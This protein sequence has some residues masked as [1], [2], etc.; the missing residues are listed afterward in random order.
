MNAK[1]K[2]VSKSGRKPEQKVSSKLNKKP[3]ATPVEAKQDVLKLK[4]SNFFTHYYQQIFIFL[5]ASIALYWTA[6]SNDFYLKWAEEYSLFIPTRY[7]FQDCMKFSGGLLTYTGTFLT[8]FYYYPALGSII[9]IAI[10]FLIQYLTLKTFR[11]SRKYYPLS[12]VPVLMLL[13]SIT[14]LGYVWMLLKSPGYFFSNA[15][16]IAAFL[17]MFIVYRN[18][19]NV[20]LR[21]AVLMLVIIAGYPLFGFYALY[22]GFLCVFYELIQ[23]IRNKQVLRMIPVVAGFVLIVVVPLYFYYY[24]YHY[25]QFIDIYTAGLPRFEYNLRELVL[26]IPFLVILSAFVLFVA[27]LFPKADKDNV[28]HRGGYLLSVSTFVLAVVV[29]CTMSYRDENFTAGTRIYNAIEHNNWNRV[30]SIVENLEGKPTKNIV[31]CYRMASLLTISK[32]AND[33]ELTQENTIPPRCIR[34]TLPIKV[35]MG[36]ISFYYNSGEINKCYRWC[37]ENSVEFGMRVA[38]LKYMVKCA[39]VNG[40]YKLAEKYNSIL[41]SSMFYK[42]WAKRYQNF[43]ENP[44]LTKDD[45]EMVL[46]RSLID[47]NEQEFEQ[48]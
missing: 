42:S 26:W 28:K 3:V 36:G 35:Q 7:Y 6:V 34:A 15:L 47:V 18:T 39:I 43:I 5:F 46:L 30:I 17:L 29:T 37:M 20:A 8:Q 4:L 19:S 24:V 22:T 40:E 48:L 10:L 12:F 23:L 31:L 14:Q 16:G 27:F 33:A 45:N 9:F 1:K 25:T 13:L 11:I 41:M 2:S 21:T 32:A 44:E 38:Y